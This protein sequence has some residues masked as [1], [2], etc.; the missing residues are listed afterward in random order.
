[1]VSFGSVIDWF[2]KNLSG[3][4]RD[5]VTLDYIVYYLERKFIRPCSYL[6]NNFIRSELCYSEIQGLFCY[7]VLLWILLLIVCETQ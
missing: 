4:A 5:P 2:D 3:I 7:A 1:M 6:V